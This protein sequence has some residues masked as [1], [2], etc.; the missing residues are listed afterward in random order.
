MKGRRKWSEIIKI[1]KEK[2]KK[3]QNSNPVKLFS[4]NKEEIMTF[5]DR[6]KL[7]KFIANRSAQQEML[8][9]EFFIQMESGIVK[10]HTFA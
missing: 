2:E 1:L 5:I 3:Q 6:Q 10:K 4:R 7:R 9:T 8:K